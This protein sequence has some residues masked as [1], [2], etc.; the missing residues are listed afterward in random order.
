ME[1]ASK[2]AGERSLKTEQELSN[3]KERQ[4]P[5]RKED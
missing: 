2:G 3:E 1:H 5:I 4:I